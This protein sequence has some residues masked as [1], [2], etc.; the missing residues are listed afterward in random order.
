MQF[1]PINY[2]FINAF[3]KASYSIVIYYLRQFL[4]WNR[5]QWSWGKPLAS[6][7]EIRPNNQRN[8][9]RVWDDC[10]P[11]AEQTQSG[12]TGA[13]AGRTGECTL[14]VSQER[15]GIGEPDCW[16]N[17]EAFPCTS[18]YDATRLSVHWQVT[19]AYLICIM[20][21]FAKALVMYCW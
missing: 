13:L 2:N 17:G 12:T 18:Q 10:R 11:E 9:L 8:S 3:L 6:N 16:R 1:I 20:Q 15:A 7:D 19:C 5:S 4:T 21:S 14:R